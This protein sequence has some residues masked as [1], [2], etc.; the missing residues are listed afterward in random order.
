MIAGK[1][2]YD[3][4]KK[5]ESELRLLKTAHI[6]TATTIS[7]TYRTAVVKFSLTKADYGGNTYSTQDA[8]IEATTQNGDDMVCACYIDGLT[9]AVL[10][11]RLLMMDGLA[12]EAGK[13][14]FR[15]TVLSGNA[16]DYNILSG[17]GEVNITYVVRVVGTSEFNLTVRYVGV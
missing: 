4:L 6:K 12:A 15:L 14:S 16:Q 5:L 1:L 2:L 8:I 3:K 11:D 17:G 10:D 13:R 7:T 9:P